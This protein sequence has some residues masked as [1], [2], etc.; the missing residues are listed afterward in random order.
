MFISAEV[1]IV[2]LDPARS[3]KLYTVQG[4]FTKESKTAKKKID[5]PAIVIRPFGYPVARVRLY[6]GYHL[7]KA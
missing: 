4:S 6:F 3:K 2:T 5:S 7:L 1:S